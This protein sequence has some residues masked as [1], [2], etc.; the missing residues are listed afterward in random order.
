L[1]YKNDIKA[2]LPY[3][4]E[5]LAIFEKLNDKQQLATCVSNIATA[6]YAIG[7]FAQSVT[8]YEKAYGLIYTVATPG[9]AASFLNDLG[10]I[11]KEWGDY[12]KAL[13]HFL[14]AVELNKTAN[15]KRHMA[16]VLHNVGGLYFEDGKYELAKAYYNQGLSIEQELNNTLGIPFSYVS[17]SALFM[18][19]HQYDSAT[20]YLQKALAGFR[21]TNNLQGVSTALSHLG[22]VA[23]Q[24][25]NVRSSRDYYKQAIEHS[26]QIGDRK[27]LA[28]ALSGYGH[29]LVSL[30]QHSK[31]IEHLLEAA[32][33][34]EEG[35]Y[36]RLLEKIYQYLSE[37]Y[38]AGGNKG[39]VISSLKNYIRI[40]DSVLTLEKRRQASELLARYESEKK[41]NRIKLL[42]KEK[43]INASKLKQQRLFNVV[44]VT[45]LLVVVLAIVFL[46]LRYRNNKRVNS[47]LNAKNKEIT[48][49][50]QEIERQNQTLAAQTQKLK[51]LDEMK[52]RFFT[53]ISH[54]FRTPLTLI[55]GPLEQLIG[56]T[57][58]TDVRSSLKLMMRN[59]RRLLELINQLLNISRLEQGKEMLNLQQIDICEHLTFIAEMFTSKTKEKGVKLEFRCADGQVNGL[60]DQEKIDQVVFN[61]LSN[62][63]KNTHTGEISVTVSQVTTAMVQ[64]E[65]RDTGGGIEKTKIP[66][67]FD[68]FYTSGQGLESSEVS[69]GIGLA[70]VAELVKLH[71]GTIS[72]ESDLGQGTAFTIMLPSQ[73]GNLP[74]DAYRILPARKQ[75]AIANL[76]VAIEQTE[77]SGIVNTE[78]ISPTARQALERVLVV[79]DHAEL[80]TFI[81][82]N[83][84]VGVDVKEAANGVEALELIEKEQPDLI[85][86]DIMMPEMDGIELTRRIK[87]QSETSHIPIIMLTAK[88]SEESRIEG[89]ETRADDYL[90]KP[91]SI[92]ELMLRVEN[93]LAMRRRLREK[94]ND[95]L[96]VNPS[97]ITTNS[98][99]AEFMK[100]MLQ[101]VEVNMGNPDFS[102]DMLCKAVGVSRTTL[103]KKLKS[104]VNQSAT[105]F[106]NHIR[107]KRAAQ[108]IKQKAGN[109]SEIAYDVGYN[110]LSYFSRQFKK[111]FGITP[112]EMMEQG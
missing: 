74:S 8:Y 7:D 32:Q 34:A 42:N 67:I 38:E 66:Y 20:V 104:I 53:N 55:I 27:G 19:T 4:R 48:R 100:K 16:T 106:I 29:A 65:V 105:E 35:N 69:S 47:L 111:Q 99:D 37:A 39:G 109:I 86:T 43:E 87:T 68:R 22:N 30:G 12:S 31:A 18:E 62:A 76:P 51:Q 90:T 77:E 94:Y 5:S 36:V 52:T 2:A 75:Q 78:A 44:V 45:M 1:W 15:N 79:D 21:T 58:D 92:R 54:E 61:L 24:T 82:R 108:L 101:E 57:S 97:E 85:I 40:R 60:F 72:V 28:H 81:C 84:P 9:E 56:H 102:V 91:F 41:E 10:T 83:M 13:E 88:A 71:G 80:R 6:Y 14:R 112:R 33:L 93:I 64:I 107:M 73:P 50:Q 95:A 98:V 59:A 96:S 17:L 70:Y 110:S 23:Q 25:G 49:K 3:Y 63:I 26:T 103:H 46:Y 89:L 11:Y